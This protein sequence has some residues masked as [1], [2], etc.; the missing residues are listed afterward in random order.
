MW[1]EIGDRNTPPQLVL[2]GHYHSL[3]NETFTI[4]TNNQCYESRLVVVPPLCG[5]GD[6]ARKITR[7]AHKVTEGGA[8][9]EIIDN[10]LLP[11]IFVTE[12]IDI[13]KKEIL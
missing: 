7:S 6:F 5:L 13:R 8:I 3:I 4:Y 9:F 2:R 12:T 1:D 11:T 10:K